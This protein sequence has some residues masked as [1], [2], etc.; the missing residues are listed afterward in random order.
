MKKCYL[1]LLPCAS[2]RCARLELVIRWQSLVLE[3][4][5]IISRRG[6]SKLFIS[7]HFST[8][9]S[10][11]VTDFLRHYDILWEFILQKSS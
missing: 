8:F 4:K 1:L 2:T 10:K 7:D 3:L 6:T 11:E 5:R 9:K